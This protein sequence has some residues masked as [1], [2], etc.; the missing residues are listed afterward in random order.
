VF[1]RPESLSVEGQEHDFVHVM[2]HI[3]NI[4]TYMHVDRTQ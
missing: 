3:I 4:K 2:K 1:I